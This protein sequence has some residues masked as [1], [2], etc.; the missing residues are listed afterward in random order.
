[1]EAMHGGP[2]LRKLIPELLKRSTAC[3]FSL[4]NLEVSG[5]LGICC[6]GPEGCFPKAGV[7]LEMSEVLRSCEVFNF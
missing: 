1:M 6:V 5:V 2:F 3:L 4:L 7:T